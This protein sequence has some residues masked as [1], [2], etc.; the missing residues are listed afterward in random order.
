MSKYM[1]VIEES[2]TGYSAYL[3]DLLAYRLGGRFAM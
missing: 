2:A 3:P 1:I